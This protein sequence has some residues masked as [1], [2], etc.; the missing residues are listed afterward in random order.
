MVW[1]PTVF[2]RFPT[3]VCNKAAVGVQM[4]YAPWQII[5]SRYSFTQLKQAEINRIRAGSKLVI[6]KPV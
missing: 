6:R 1:L 3:A 4:T 2:Q 5:R